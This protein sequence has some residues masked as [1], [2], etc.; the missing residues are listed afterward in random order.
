MH[1][2]SSSVQTQRPCPFSPNLALEPRVTGDVYLHIYLNLTMMSDSLTE[3]KSDLTNWFDYKN[4]P[5]QL[6]YAANI[7]HKLDELNQKL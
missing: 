3:N 7:L 2:T 1:L 5:W 6:C 4:W